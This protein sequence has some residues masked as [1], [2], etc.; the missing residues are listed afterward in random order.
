AATST[1][2]ALQAPGGVGLQAYLSSA[3]TNAPVLVSVD[4]FEATGLAGN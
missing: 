2:A 1:V 4:D 3:A